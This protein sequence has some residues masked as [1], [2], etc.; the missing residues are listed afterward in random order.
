MYWFFGIKVFKIVLY[1]IGIVIDFKILSFIWFW[2]E[3]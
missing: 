2:G 3:E 1:I